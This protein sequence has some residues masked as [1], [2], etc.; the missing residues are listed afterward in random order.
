MSYSEF[1]ATQ[2][3]QVQTAINDYRKAVPAIVAAVQTL[4]KASAEKAAIQA[5]LNGL[6][7]GD[8]LAYAN[9]PQIQNPASPF[10][11]KDLTVDQFGLCDVVVQAVVSAATSNDAKTTL[12]WLT[13]PENI[14]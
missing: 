8:V 5:L 13:G 3:L 7:G 14:L 12:G 4:K 9:D 10:V 1:T 6:S 2:K 11:L